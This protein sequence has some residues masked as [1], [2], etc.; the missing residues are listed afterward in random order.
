[1]SRKRR[2]A[3]RVRPVRRATSESV[4]SGSSGP[5]ARMTASPRSS[6]WTKCS[7][8]SRHRFVQRLLGERHGGV[9]G[10]DAGV[11]R[12]V[13][14]H[15]EDLLG[16]E[17]VADRGA[18]VHRDLVLGPSAVRIASVMHERVLRSRPGRVHA[19]PQAERVMYSWNGLRELGGVVE[20]AVDVL[21]AEHLAAD[22]H[23]GLVARVV[24]AQVLEDQAR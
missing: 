18:D 20:R 12:G 11:D 6:D 13:D 9:R 17:A 3:A 15:L 4:S 21:V 16:R 8:R 1:M 2:A 10:R 24:H 19:S 7:P 22:L 14:Q 5:N 23:A